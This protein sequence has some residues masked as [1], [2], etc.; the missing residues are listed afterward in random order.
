MLA[1][2]AVACAACTLTGLGDYGVLTCAQPAGTTT[3][4]EGVGQLADTP[5]FSSLSGSPMGAFV[6]ND[7]V[8]GVWP[9]GYVQ[10]TCTLFH[11]GLVAVQPWIVPIGDGYA[12][13]TIATTAPCTQGQLS[14]ATV[15]GAGASPPAQAQCSK[16]GAALPAIA[17]LGASSALVLWYE[18]TAASRSDPLQQCR[19]A[20]A[21]PLRV[22]MVDNA[23][24][25]QPSLG[26]PTTLTTQSVSV[27]PPAVTVLQGTGNV[28]IAT[29]DGRAVSLWA[30]P[31]GVR[32]GTPLSIS[33]LA[34]ARAVSIAS[35]TDGSGRIGV[36]AEIGCSPQSI[37]LA[38]GTL[39]G[40]WHVAT[41]ASAGSGPAVQPTVAWVPSQSDW[42]VSW[43]AVSGGA[44]ALARRFDASGEAAGSAIDPSVP[45]IGAALASDGSLLA[46][47]PS[48]GGNFVKAAL[49]CAP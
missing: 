48:G 18:T 30:T 31:D 45:A 10:S 11:G 13:A 42:I 2:T 32:F 38:I 49:G 24:S 4:V 37:A 23:T 36:V 35:A 25:I 44:H 6:S 17:P 19:G 15:T 21:A 3:P 29:P 40:G 12:A 22:A 16:A 27:R 14:F 41:V 43:I 33:A 46:Y 28:L 1:P 20:T 5:S 47:E 7:C 26:T 9:Q 34:G 39:S 8:E